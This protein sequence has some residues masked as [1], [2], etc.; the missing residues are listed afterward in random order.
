MQHDDSQAATSCPSNVNGR[1]T[2]QPACTC[3]RTDRSWWPMDLGTSR[4][5]MRNT[6]QTGISPS[7]K[8]WWRSHLVRI[9]LG[10]SWDCRPEIVEWHVRGSHCT[11]L[12]VRHF[13]WRVGVRVARSRNRCNAIGPKDTRE[14]H[15]TRPASPPPSRD[16]SGLDYTICRRL[17][18]RARAG[19]LG[20]LSAFRQL[21]AGD[22]VRLPDGPRVE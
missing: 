11:R 7:S 3:C 2:W 22:R 1:R 21:W 19:V 4:S 17:S 8:N 12:P 6:R 5:L 10:Q 13:P 18:D 9:S 15:L 20:S 14:D 16:R